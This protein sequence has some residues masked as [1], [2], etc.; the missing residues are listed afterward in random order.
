MIDCSSI[1]SIPFWWIDTTFGKLVFTMFFVTW[2]LVIV[3]L[4]LQ[5]L[6]LL[7]RLRLGAKS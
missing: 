7:K 5:I 1:S 6:V 2:G 4:V 3:T